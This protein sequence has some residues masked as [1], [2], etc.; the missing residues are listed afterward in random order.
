VRDLERE[1]KA[2]RCANEIVRKTS[3]PSGQRALLLRGM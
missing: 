3:L 2:L 1:V